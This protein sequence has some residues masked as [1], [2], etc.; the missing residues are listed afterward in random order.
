MDGK[1]ESISINCSDRLSSGGTM[2]AVHSSPPR[3]GTSVPQ[4]NLDDRDPDLIPAETSPASPPQLPATSASPIFFGNDGLR[5]GWSLLLF[6]IIAAALFVPASAIITLARTRQLPSAAI[7]RSADRSVSMTVIADGVLLLG[8]ALSTA[9]M[10]RIERRPIAAYGLGH[11]PGALRH[12]LAGLFWGFV[13]LS[14]LVL[15]LWSSHLLVFDGHLL[16][17]G[18][19]LRFGAE[20]AVAFLLV[21]LFEEYLLRGFLQFTLARALSGIYGAISA[22]RLSD[23]LGFWTAAVILSFVFGISHSTNPGESPLGLFTAG[24]AALVFLFSLWRTGSLWWAIGFH[25]AWDWAQSFLYGVPDSGT[26]MQYHLLA[27]HPVG[28]PILSGG[29]TGPEGSIFVFPV[30]VV[31]SVIIGVTLPRRAPSRPSKPSNEC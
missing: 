29:S 9:A 1:G 5:A 31:A 11:T 20:W 8:V 12:L 13:C 27:S 26:M 2:G 18:S 24:C 25:T 3:N 21:G 10:S 14:A 19:T 23:L 7:S 4:N 22:T 6:L 17:G 15:V 28:R 30:L 16:S